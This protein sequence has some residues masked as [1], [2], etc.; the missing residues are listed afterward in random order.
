VKGPSITALLITTA[1]CSLAHEYR[2][3]EV[4]RLQIYSG[5]TLVSQLRACEHV[6][7]TAIRRDLESR[8]LFVSTAVA[9]GPDCSSPF[10][11]YLITLEK[12]RPP[13]RMSMPSEN[14]L[15]DD[16]GTVLGTDTP[17]SSQPSFSFAGGPTIEGYLDVRRDQS[18]APYYSTWSES[19]GTQV[20][21]LVNSQRIVARSRLRGR[22]IS[23]KNRHY[24]CGWLRDGGRGQGACDVFDSDGSSEDWRPAGRL[25][26]GDHQVVDIDPSSRLVLLATH[27]D[28]L[29]PLLFTVDLETWDWRYIGA[30]P[31]W[32]L[33]FMNVDPLGRP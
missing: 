10:S 19:K 13:T 12:G 14:A 27:R 6:E 17:V 15:I 30:G 21:G 16:D 31:S 32:F 29:E 4:P 18:G 28:D 3:G 7:P 25:T 23:K 33:L 2:S 11:S 1:G 8:R 20:A 22:L 26:F 9:E 5:E 24:I